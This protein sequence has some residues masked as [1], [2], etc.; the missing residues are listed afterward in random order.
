MLLTIKKLK[1]K[2]CNKEK[3]K[4]KNKIGSV[5]CKSRPASEERLFSFVAGTKT[6]G[7]APIH[8]SAATKESWDREKRER[9]KNVFKIH[10]E[11]AHSLM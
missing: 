2:M 10:L 8:H 11:D 6:T 7:Q 4:N 9:R 1:Q 5:E 3:R